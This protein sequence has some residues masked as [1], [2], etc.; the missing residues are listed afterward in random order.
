[1]KAVSM[2]KPSRLAASLV[3]LVPAVFYGQALVP[4]QDAYIVPGNASSFGSAATITL[5]GAL[6]A[7]GVV[8]FDLTQ[9]PAGLLSSQV[10]KATLTL[11]V[12]HVSAAGAVNIYVADGAWT[13]ASA[14]AARLRRRQPID[15]H[16]L[17]T[18][19]S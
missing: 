2:R 6:N 1:M 3:C 14:C 8:G 9:L 4:S 16:A 19:G 7:Q 5:G 12:D 13:E 10:T 11:Y 15:F 18:R 17:A